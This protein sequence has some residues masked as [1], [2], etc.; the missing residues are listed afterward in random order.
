MV[1]VS[2]PLDELLVRTEVLEREG[3]FTPFLVERR[4]VVPRICEP[5]RQLESASICLDRLP[6][7]SEI[8]CRD[9]DVEPGRG[10]VAT[11]IEGRSILI[12]GFTNGA[13]R[14]EEAAEVEVRLDEARVEVDRP[15]VCR[16]GFGGIRVA[17]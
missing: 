13:A 1:T 16:L 4:Q 9:T 3:D 7:P 12:E 14:V 10:V 17:S 8:V 6:I 2:S 11:G 5:R 15:A